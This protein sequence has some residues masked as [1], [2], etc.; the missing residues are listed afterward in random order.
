MNTKRFA[1]GDNE[2]PG[3]GTYSFPDTVVVK[4]KAKKSSMFK[5]NAD[6]SLELVMGKDN[7]GVGEYENNHQGTMANKEF[8]GGA[9]NNFV[10][11][12]R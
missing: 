5:S 1:D 12:T 4:D 3:A 8:Q 7:P 11:F 10:L 9:A 2:V 6:K